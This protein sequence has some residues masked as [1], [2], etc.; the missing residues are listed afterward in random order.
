MVVL[1]VMAEHLKLGAITEILRSQLNMVHQHHRLHM[2]HL[3][4]VK[5]LLS[6]QLHLSLLAGLRSGT[7]L[8]KS[9]H[10]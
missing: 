4:M 3:S 1:Q 5:A 8:D 7:Q 10:I 2:A 6:L 9:G